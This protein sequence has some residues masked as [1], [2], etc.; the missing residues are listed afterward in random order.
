M[1]AGSLA[2]WVGVPPLSG[3]LYLVVPDKQYDSPQLS[4][5]LAPPTVVMHEQASALLQEAAFSDTDASFE[6][7][8]LTS[9]V[10]T[11]F[12]AP[13][14]TAPVAP[15]VVNVHA[16][17]A[18]VVPLQLAAPAVTLAGEPEVHDHSLMP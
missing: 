14:T 1:Q 5:L 16:Q 18:G 8:Q 17:V 4:V 10:P 15:P 7:E 3:Q 9:L 13:Q 12:L 11:H 6:S 2:V